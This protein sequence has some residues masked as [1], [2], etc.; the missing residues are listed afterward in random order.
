MAPPTFSHNLDLVGWLTTGCEEFS[1][2]VDTF[3]F[4]PDFF[5]EFYKLTSLELQ[6]YDS[7]VIKF[8]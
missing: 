3:I 2:C 1:H 5:V 6:G 4:F 7:L 8:S